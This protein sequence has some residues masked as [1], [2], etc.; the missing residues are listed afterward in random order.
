MPTQSI[1]LDPYPTLYA[2]IKVKLITKVKVK[3]KAVKLSEEYIAVNLL[4]LGLG[5]G[6]S[7]TRPKA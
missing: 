7:E 3:S 1:N 6:F 2:K 4:D 5:T